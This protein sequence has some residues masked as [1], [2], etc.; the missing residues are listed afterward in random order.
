MEVSEEV[1]KPG[2]EP[3]MLKKYIAYSKRHIIPLLTPDSMDLLV[4][5]YADLRGRGEGGAIPITA[6]QF[7]AMIRLAEAAARLRLSNFIE[8]EDCVLATGIMDYCLRNIGLD[9][10]TGKLDIDMI[11]GKPAS[12]RNK[13]SR[14]REII[15]ELESTDERGAEENEVIRIAESEGIS[16]SQAIETIRRLKSEGMVYEPKN[17]RLRS[18]RNK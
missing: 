16:A 2:I 14:I 5:Y 8:E 4:N 18:I 17:G 9:S 11:I 15:N 12:Q 3:T 6:R 1:A 10:E 13:M 7:E